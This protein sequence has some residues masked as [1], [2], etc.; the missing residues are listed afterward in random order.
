MR[1]ETMKVKVYEKLGEAQIDMLDMLW[2]Q[3]DLE[4]LAADGDSTSNRIFDSLTKY[5]VIIDIPVG[6]DETENGRVV[7]TDDGFQWEVVSEVVEPE[8]EPEPLP[9][10]EPEIEP[11]PEVVEPEPEPEVVVHDRDAEIVALKE[12]LKRSKEHVE[13]L[14]ELLTRRDDIIRAVV[15]QL[16]LI[17]TSS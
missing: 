10:P 2:E 6:D 14:R 9:E 13:I 4:W 11:E 15:R 8:A 7:R 5:D 1:M 12:Q 17:D 16:K 3:P